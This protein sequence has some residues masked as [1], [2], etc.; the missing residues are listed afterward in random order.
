MKGKVKL[1]YEGLDGKIYSENLKSAKVNGILLHSTPDK[2][3]NRIK[4]NGL[5]TKMPKT[6]LLVDL[7]AIFCTVAGDNPNTND[8]FRY[9]D[10]WSIV[11]IDADKIP[12][13]KWFIDFLAEDEMKSNGK[14]NRHIMT[15]ENIP[16]TAI[17]KI[18]K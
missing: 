3:V 2:N 1:K 16:P 5:K 12:N 10:D 18:I 15:F 6:K 14:P 11:V 8:L 4:R 7:D 9:Y 13:H 17:K